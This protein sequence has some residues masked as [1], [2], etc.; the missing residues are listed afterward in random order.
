MDK[1]K[2]IEEI[3]NSVSKIL[4]KEICVHSCDNITNCEDIMKASKTLY[5]YDIRKIPEGSVVIS[6]DEYEEYLWLKNTIQA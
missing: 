1:E 5:D 2:Q 4:C 3:A 6:K